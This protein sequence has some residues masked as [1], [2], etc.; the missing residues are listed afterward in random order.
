MI[1]AIL[2]RALFRKQNIWRAMQAAMRKK[3]FAFFQ[4]LVASL[5]R[6]PSILDVGGT[7]EFWAKMEFA[8]E[9]VKIVLY[10][11]ARF[12]TPYPGMVSLAGDAC[13]MHEFAEQQF[14]I[15]FSNSV[16]EHVGS[17]ERQ[18]QMAEEVK[19]VGK[20]YY[21]QT[22]DR[23]FPIEP[24]VLL[25]FFQF[26]P[27]G[28]QVF[29]LTHFRSPWG[30]KIQGREEAEEYVQAIRLLTEAELRQLFPDAKIYKEKF[31]GLTKS[32]VVCG[33]W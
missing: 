6:S 26:L 10:N 20:R 29:L 7:P 32:F 28:L 22:P 17:Y 21:V 27:F 3:R 2:W 14:D 9:D 19:R 12:D 25:P 8:D 4:V 1:I 31:L 15:V 11:L 13:A 33:G 30:W 18:R 23:Y 5:A 16:I 24:H